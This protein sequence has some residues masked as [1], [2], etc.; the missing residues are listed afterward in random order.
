[1]KAA[2]FEYVRANSVEEACALL[3]QHVDG[4]KLIAGGQSLVPLMAFRLVRPAWLININ[5][6]PALK[7]VSFERD[8]VRTGACVRQCVMERDDA[9]AA[10]VPLLRQAL[11]WVGHAQTRNRGTIG[12]SLAHADRP[13]NCRW[14]P[15]FWMPAWACVT[16]PADG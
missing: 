14:S 16:N 15:K 3:A 7:R 4:A 6:I 9:L 8:A 1:M 13:Q 2:A 11:A 5:E 10:S 12:G